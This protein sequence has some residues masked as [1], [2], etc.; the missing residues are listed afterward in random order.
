MSK[1]RLLDLFCGAGGCTAGYQRAGF[2]V[3]GVDIKHQPRYCG[4]EFIQADAVHYLSELVESGCINQFDA[5][6]ASPP[7]QAHTALKTMWNA[8]QHLDLIEPT[9]ELLKTSGLP[10]VIEN[11]EGAPLGFAI[12]LCGTMFGL[13]VGDAELRRHRRFE[14]NIFL[15]SN[16]CQHGR[17]AVIGVYGG[18]ARNRTRTIG[19]YGEGAR[20][21]RRKSDRGVADFTVEDAREAM[22]IDWMTLAELC[23]AIP[24]AYTEMIGRQL[25]AAIEMKE[26]A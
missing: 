22:G 20:D 5:I 16:H 4:D 8:K 19:V 12:N 3:R 15:F 13:G 23:Q 9:R 7:C 1:P 25:I 21:S 10:Y 17:P 14:S 2:W 18:H 26:A 6:H 11:V 24:P